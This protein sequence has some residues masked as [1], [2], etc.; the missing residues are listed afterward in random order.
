MR[1][2]RGRARTGQQTSLMRPSP[3][4][5]PRWSQIDRGQQQHDHGEPCPPGCPAPKKAQD[6]SE[7]EQRAE[8]GRRA[9]P[10]TGAQ[11]C[12]SARRKM[13]KTAS[14]MK[15]EQRR[16]DRR[17]QPVR[18]VEGWFDQ[19]RR[20]SQPICGTVTAPPATDER[21]RHHRHDRKKGKASNT[22]GGLTVED[23]LLSD[24]RHCGEDGAVSALSGKASPLAVHAIPN[25][26]DGIDRRISGTFPDSNADDQVQLVA[27]PFARRPGHG[28]DRPADQGRGTT[29][30]SSPPP[31][32]ATRTT[33]I[34]LGLHL[35]PSGQ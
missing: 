22:F 31:I 21:R 25:A 9:V 29:D 19:G 24:M 8:H 7:V 16:P 32:S 35:W 10:A 14:A 17:E 3:A 33:P 2:R 11:A 13:R 4:E 6:H 18:R 15:R 26:A 23:V 30:P 12:R 27:P 34:R 1:P 28:Q 20:T 5:P